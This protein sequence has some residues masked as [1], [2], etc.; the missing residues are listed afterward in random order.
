MYTFNK[1]II[2][3][4][5]ENSCSESTGVD[6]PTSSKRPRTETP[7]R[8]SDGDPST[9]EN[10]TSDNSSQSSSADSDSSQSSNKTSAHSSDNDG[11]VHDHTLPSSQRGR[12]HRHGRGHGCGRGH[13]HGRGRGRRRSDG[14]H[15]SSSSN[16]DSSHRRHVGHCRRGRASTRVIS[17]CPTLEPVDKT[18]WVK[19]EPISYCYQYTKI[20]GPTIHFTDNTTALYI[21]TKYFTDEVWDLLVMETNRY[22]HANTSSRPH[23]RAWNDVCVEE[24]KA[25]IGMLLL[26]GII[27]LPRL[28]MFWQNSNEYIGTPGIANIMSRNRSEQ[29]FHFLHLADNTCDP[30]NDKLYEVRHFATLL[31]SQF[32][33]LYTLHQQITIDEAMVPFKCRL[34]FKQYMKAKPTKWGIKVFVLSDATNG[35]IYKLQI[36][37][38]K[39]KES[40]TNT[41]L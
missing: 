7:L 36:Y 9:F 1:M 17:G 22:A 25:F 12:G 41:G 32:Q 20:P 23:S 31:T 24:M 5:Q 15:R 35:Y 30:G 4:I 19:E 18:K 21:F 16:S 29:I 28:E 11:S 14:S 40:E 26:L 8:S 2:S 6:V 34:S 39:D 13:G 3:V 10:D 38:G 33:S 27:K 37:T